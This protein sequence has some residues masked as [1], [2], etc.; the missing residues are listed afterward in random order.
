M[1]SCVGSAE[2]ASAFTGGGAAASSPLSGGVAEGRGGFPSARSVA[3]SNMGTAA[4]SAFWPACSPVRAGDEG[5]ASVD[6]PRRCAAPPSA[7]L[8]TGLPGGDDSEAATGAA[9]V[10]AGGTASG[11][12]SVTG[13]GTAV[14]S[15][16]VGVSAVGMDS[17]VESGSTGG[18]SA[19]AFTGGVASSSPLSGGVALSL[20]KGRGGFSP[21]VSVA[22]SNE[23]TAA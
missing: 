13:S 19:S 11:A 4:W 12:G 23:G 7:G 3:V 8:R 2:G 5:G 10:S 1:V 9:A 18:T 20:S 17:G 15:T 6:P 14:V 22:V 16:G 21:G